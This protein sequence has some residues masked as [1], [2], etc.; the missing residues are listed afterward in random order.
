[1]VIPEEENAATCLSIVFDHRGIQ[2]ATWECYGGLS[3]GTKDASCNATIHWY[4]LRGAV[5]HASLT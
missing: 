3:A 2:K 4:V 5:F 1:M